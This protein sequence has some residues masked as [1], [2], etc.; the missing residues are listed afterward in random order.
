MFW[1]KSAIPSKKTLSVIVGKN[2]TVFSHKETGVHS[3][4]NFQEMVQITLV[5]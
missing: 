1:A 3:F 4:P 5:S 2:Y